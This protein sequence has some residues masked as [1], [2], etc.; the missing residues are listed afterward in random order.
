MKHLMIWA[1]NKSKGDWHMK[2]KIIISI[3]MALLCLQCSKESTPFENEDKNILELNDTEK[4][5]VE[6]SNV[7][8]LKLFNEIVAAEGDSNIFISPLSVSM[9]LGMTLNGA[10][11]S[12][13]EAMQSTLAWQNLSEKEINES[14]CHII[15]LLVGFDPKVIFEIANSIWYREGFQVEQDFIDINKTYFNAEVSSL[16]FSNPSA[17]DII[18]KWVND[19]THG[20]IEEIID[21]IDAM[22]VMFLINAL[23][24]K[25]T[26]SYEFD[27]QLTH[28]DYFY[29]PDGSAKLCAM[30]K[31][32]WE[33][34]YF[35]NDYFQ[36]I[37]LPYGDG[38]FRMT[39]FLP[40]YGMSVN[41][42][43]T[44]FTPENWNLWMTSFDKDS[45]NIFLPKFKV[46]YKIKL[47]DVLSEM[48][49]GIAFAPGSADF[50]RIRKSGGLWIDKVLH[51]T[52]VEVNEEGTEAAAVTVV[53]IR[54]I[55]A[56]GGEEIFMRVDRPFIFTIREA[57]SNTILFMGKIVDPVYNTAN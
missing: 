43:I 40:Q 8:G 9:A 27:E 31:Q 50:S 33:H 25:G 23:Y 49:M 14:Y 47:N 53:E 7:F 18:N 5:V 17:I 46:E 29:L 32:K 6:S 15:K 10:A 37:D 52:F 3:I 54:E 19:K 38:N 39:V 22:V 36:A 2:T 12:T 41:S 48:G 24:F 28:D 45:V 1:I 11:G 34:D 56:G 35:E 44:D 55:S 13:Y 30:M 16:D 57:S 20:K 26:W 21:E 4:L 51:K 42:L